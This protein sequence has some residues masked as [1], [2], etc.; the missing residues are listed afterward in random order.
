[1]VITLGTTAFATYKNVKATL[2]YQNISVT[3]DGTKLTLKDAA[4]NSVEP[5]MYNG[6]NY[7]PVRA[8]SEALGL[9]VAW[10]GSTNTVVLTTPGTASSG[11][12]SRTNPAP[13]HTSQSI[14]LENYTYGTYT[15]TVSVTDVI[16]GSEAWS[17][18]SAANMFNSAAPDGYEYL[19]AKV[20]VTISKN[21]KD[22]AVSLSQYD[23]KAYNS[24]NSAYDNPTVVEPDP[25]FSGDAYAGGSVEG[26]MTWQVSKSDPAP[27][28]VFGQKYD[29][30]GGIWFRLSNE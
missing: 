3:L 27:K 23:F 6:T 8:L 10:N 4:G 11:V 1:M 24:T 26:W 2:A 30:T 15:A 16:R 14:T 18:I 7:L 29:G 25:A 17:K 12:Y 20:K 22:S 13:V 28:M 21:T 19:L 9:N 5:F